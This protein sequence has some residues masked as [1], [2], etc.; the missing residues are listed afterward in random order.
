MHKLKIILIVIVA[1]SGSILAVLFFQD[2]TKKL[3][4]RDYKD[5]KEITI[6][7]DKANINFYKSENEKVRVEIYGSSK[8][9]AEIIEGSQKLT[10]SKMTGNTTCFLNCKNQ[11]NIYVPEDFPKVLISS[12]IGNIK[13]NVGIVGMDI[14]SDK[15]NITISKASNLTINS[16]MGN[17]VIDEINASNNSSIKTDLGNITI[18]EIVNLKIDA[19]SES[20][21]VVIP[22]IKDSQEYTLTIETNKGNVDIDHHENKS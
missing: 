7:T 8:D 20:G 5:I 18:K 14:N 12:E 11:V 15:G 1:I 13:T 6:K 10:I 9:L 3:E 16:N 21:S 2:R 4:D 22:V 17:I 19:K